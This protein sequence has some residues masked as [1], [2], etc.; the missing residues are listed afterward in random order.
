M[1]DDDD[2]VFGPMIDVTDVRILARYVLELTFETGE[3]RMIDLE[4]MLWGPIFEPLLEDY[5][6]FQQV[7]VDQEAGT[8]VW[9]SGA[10]IA[11]ETLYKESK[12]VVPARAF[13]GTG[14]PS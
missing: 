5:S 4:P 13:G 1:N 12:P 11:P 7:H 8:I 14:V 9:P 3:V 2:D 10:D 6:L